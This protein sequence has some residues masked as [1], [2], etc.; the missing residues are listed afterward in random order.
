MFF[1]FF[2]ISFFFILVSPSFKKK[3]KKV[4][5]KIGWII[6]FSNSH[7]EETLKSAIITENPRSCN[8][9]SSKNTGLNSIFQVSIEI[10]LRL[11]AYSK[12]KSLVFSIVAK[13]SQTGKAKIL[14]IVLKTLDSQKVH[15]S[16]TPCS[17]FSIEVLTENVK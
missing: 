6:S 17:V 3:P 4:R 12:D 7:I 13:C 10:L 11:Q 8:S 2:S 15:F 9:P 16:I 1:S 14:P 5:E